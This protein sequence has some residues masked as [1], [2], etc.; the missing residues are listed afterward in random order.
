M[1]QAGRRKRSQRRGRVGPW[2]LGRLHPPQ[3]IPNPL[4]RPS[5]T[6]TDRDYPYFVYAMMW[7]A[8]QP[9]DR[10][11]RYEDPLQAALEDAGL[12]DV[13]GGGSSIDEE[14]GIVYV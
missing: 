1:E 10:G 6:V 4:G 12:G 2:R 9:I 8:I 7:E 3:F 13:S 5:A 14:H 11:E